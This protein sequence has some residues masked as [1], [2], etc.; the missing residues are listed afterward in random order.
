MSDGKSVLSAAPEQ[1]T[2]TLV[3]SRLIANHVTLGPAQTDSLLYE[4]LNSWV[5]RNYGLSLN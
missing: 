5:R 3:C 2:Q 1:V 4:R